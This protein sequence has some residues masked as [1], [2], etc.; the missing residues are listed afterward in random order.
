MET[1]VTI[2][3]VTRMSNG[4]VCIAC[5]TEEGLT[6]RPVF[7]DKEIQ[8]R[9]LFDEGQAIIR[10]FARVVFDLEYRYPKIKNPHTEDWVIDPGFKRFIGIS[11]EEERLA[12]LNQ[13]LAPSISEA[14][15]AE[16]IHNRGFYVNLNQGNCSLRTIRPRSID[17]VCFNQINGNLKYRVR[18]TDQNRVQY[19]LT[20]TDLSFRYYV[21]DLREGWG[22]SFSKIGLN[23]QSRLNHP[24]TFLRLGLGRA[25]HPDKNHPQDRHYVQINGIYTFPDYLDG[26][27]F[28]DFQTDEVFSQAEN[29]IQF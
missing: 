29:E 12:V 26:K 28:A 6:I 2:T 20:V 8:E 24:N 5:V 10:P 16:V 27:C 3:D 13:T 17:F 25:W 19:E 7:R 9:W 1:T 14:F 18:F 22:Q 21:D 11:N 4:R 23:L 15:G